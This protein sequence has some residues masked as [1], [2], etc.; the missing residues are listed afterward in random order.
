LDGGSSHRKASTYTGHQSTEEHGHTSMPRAG[1]EPTIPGFERSNNMRAL[2]S[3]ASVNGRTF[4]HL[5]TIMLQET[6]VPYECADEPAH[7]IH[8]HHHHHQF[9]GRPSWPVAIQNFN[10]RNLQ[11]YLTFGTTPWTEDRPDARPLPSPDNTTQK[12]ANT[13]PCLERDSIPRSQCSS[14]QRH[15]VP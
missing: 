2:D 13:H 3:A 12:K 7:I 8:H 5:F 11:I 9:Q 1:F 6:I 10:F 15:Y 14:G 4:L